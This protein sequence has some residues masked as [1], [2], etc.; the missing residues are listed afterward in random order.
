[1]YI[2]NLN[3]GGYEQCLASMTT[4]LIIKPILW[5]CS[6][7]KW[8]KIIPK[9]ITR[10]DPRVRFGP[11]EG[12]GVVWSSIRI[13]RW[14]QNARR[15]PRKMIQNG[16]LGVEGSADFGASGKTMFFRSVI[17]RSRIRTN[18]PKYDKRP[19]SHPQVVADVR[20]L[21]SRGRGTAVTYQRNRLIQSKTTSFLRS[22]TPLG[23]RPL[24]L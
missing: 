4:R 23:W 5:T 16:A 8:W 13:S 20:T 18:W 2:L 6:A 10:I 22:D 21:G 19:P 9:G 15:V 11:S 1:M 7:E 14:S 3:L 17:N 12:K 24:N